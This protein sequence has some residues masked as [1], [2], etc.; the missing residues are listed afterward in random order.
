M[1]VPLYDSSAVPGPGESLEAGA[2]LGVGL[3]AMEAIVFFKEFWIFF[4]LKKI[5]EK[6]LQIS[7]PNLTSPDNSE[8]SQKYVAKF[9]GNL[10]NILLLLLLHT[11]LHTLD[12]PALILT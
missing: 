4:S 8:L 10:T 6:N 5:V 11:S 1:N 12:S 7:A 2:L 3:D 9:Y